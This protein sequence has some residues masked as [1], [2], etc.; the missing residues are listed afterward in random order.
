VRPGEEIQL[1]E[2]PT[3]VK[4]CCESK[5]DYTVCASLWGHH[6]MQKCLQTGPPGCVLCPFNYGTHRMRPHLHKAPPFTF[7][8]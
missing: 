2:W 6:M 4:P 7:C 5:K 3:I 1:R 8:E